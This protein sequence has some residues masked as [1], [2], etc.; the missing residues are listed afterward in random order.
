MI[1]AC[2]KTFVEKRIA[3]NRKQNRMWNSCL[4]FIT[5]EIW[6]LNSPE[7]NPLYNYVRE[8]IRGRLQ[9]SSKTEDIA[10]LKKML[11]MTV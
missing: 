7:L 4:D 9:V 1:S 3:E 5:K 11:Q 6:R 10:E 2:S 8:N